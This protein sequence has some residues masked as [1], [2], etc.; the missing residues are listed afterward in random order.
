MTDQRSQADDL[1]PFVFNLVTKAEA[2]ADPDSGVEGLSGVYE[3]LPKNPSYAPLCRNAKDRRVADWF[4]MMISMCGRSMA[5]AECTI[6]D[7]MRA[8][9]SR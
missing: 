4:C 6:E 3:P 9:K 1:F 7:S 5:E 8:R 2:L